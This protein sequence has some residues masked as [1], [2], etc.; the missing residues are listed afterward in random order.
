MVSLDGTD[1]QTQRWRDDDQLGALY[2]QIPKDKTVYVYCHDGFRMCLAGMQLRH[3][4]YQD[5][6]LY[7][8]G[9]SHWGNSLTLPV[10][11]G[12]PPYDDEFGL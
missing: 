1:G 8:G 12:D 2:A 4:G 5:M 11:L 9:W 3:L 7:N 6:R 10:A